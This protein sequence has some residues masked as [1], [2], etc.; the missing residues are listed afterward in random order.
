MRAGARRDRGRRACDLGERAGTSRARSGLRCAEE[1]AGVAEVGP[2][3]NASPAK[4][5][6]FLL[7]LPQHKP[8]D[9]DLFASKFANGTP[10]FDP[11]G[12]AIF[13]APAPP[14]DE[15]QVRGKLEE[16]MSGSPDA[17]KALALFDR[18]DLKAKLDDPT[19]RASLAALYGTVAEPVIDEF[20]ARTYVRPP[21][22]CGCLPSAAGIAAATGGGTFIAFNNRYQNEHFALLSGIFAHEILHQSAVSATAPEEVILNT[23][24]A[25]VHTQILNSAPALARSRTELSRYMNDWPLMLLNSRPP[26]TSRSAVIAPKGRG[27]HP[28]SARTQPDLWSHSVDFHALGRKADAQTSTPAPAVLGAVIRSVAAKGVTLPTPLT[29]SKQTRGLLSPMNDRWL[30]PVERLRVSVLLENDPRWRRSPRTR[31]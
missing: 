31:S 29:F 26:G 15:A 23:L 5:A 11:E 20:L 28:G 14:P 13:P 10:W 9:V 8:C 30:S 4:L 21:H 2:P 12:T 27:N 17:A 16:F 24:T 1:A 6:A 25:L 22:F 3:P 18:A 7:A 19:L